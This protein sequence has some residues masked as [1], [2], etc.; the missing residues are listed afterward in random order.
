M[1]GLALVLLLQARAPTVGDTVWL[2]RT[3]VAPAA[4][5][6]EPRRFEGRAGEFDP[7]GPPD[8]ARAGDRATL[9]WPVVF[10]TTGRQ[11]VELPAV[12]LTGA[13]GSVDSV[14]PLPAVVEVAS[15][16]PSAPRDSALAPQPPAGVV[17]VRHRAWW[18]ALVALLAAAAGA[19][20]LWRRWGS[21]GEP[22]ATPG[23]L[24]AARPPVDRWAAAGETRAVAHSAAARLRAAIAAAFPP[25]DET[26]D[27]ER[28]LRLLADQRPAWPL[29]DLG[30][31][32]RGL[33]ILRFGPDETGADPFA[34]WTEADALATRL[35]AGPR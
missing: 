21:R 23:T 1:T 19:W 28:C 10:W 17:P 25:A 27:T 8:I 9:R 6:V 34:L 32:L 3:L 12:L 13:D 24:P 4:S 7:L 18:P 15:V 11:E 2:A 31:C 35:E 26:L 20:L 30:R 16:L 33:D 29:E 22:P 5:R 14:A